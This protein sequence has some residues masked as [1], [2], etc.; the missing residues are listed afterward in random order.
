MTDD[1]QPGLRA[2]MAEGARESLGFAIGALM[3]GVVFGSAAVAV[4]MPVAQGLVMS[5][6]AFAGAAQF[7]VLPLWEHPLSFLAIAISVALVSTR[8]ILMGL[9][10]SRDLRRAGWPLRLL[11][12]F[13]L[14]DA[15]WALA[16]RHRGRADLAAFF[17][18]SSLAL[19]VAW[20]AGV[21]VGG[22][23]PGLLGPATIAALGFGGVIFL[24][25]IIVL[26]VRDRVGP[27][28]PWLVS[29]VVAVAISPFAPPSLTLLAAVGAGAASTLLL[30]DRRA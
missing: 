24:G 27:R 4:G 14:V 8:N 2:S 26:L 23:L 12:I 11:A 15:S 9:S 16:M 5:A 7:A 21:A 10:L 6:T 17:C 25:L 28:L 19:Y 20:M 13:T 29:A 22:M 1:Q 30:P 3:F 18:G